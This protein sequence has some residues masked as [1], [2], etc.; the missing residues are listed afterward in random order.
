[1]NTYFRTWRDLKNTFA[2]AMLVVLALGFLSWAQPAKA[3]SVGQIQTG[4]YFAPE[5]V[6]LLRDRLFAGQGGLRQGDVIN[7]IIQF[8][9]VANGATI[10]AGGYVTDYI[11]AGT[12]VV[13]AWFV[14][15]S[16]AGY[17][18]IAPTQVATM[19]DGWG[20]RG[21]GTFNA[22]WTPDAATI[23]ACTNAGYSVATCTARLSE[24]YGDTGIFFS[25][26]PRTAVY[27]YPSTDGRVRQGGGATGNGYYATPTAE[28]QLNPFLFQSSNTTHNYWDAS[29]T[30]AFGSDAIPTAT[31]RSDIPI[32][33]PSGKGAGPFNAGSAVAGPDTGYKLDYTGTQ[34]PWQRIY[35]P[36]SVIGTSALGPATGDGVSTIAGVPTSLGWGLSAG[37]PLPNNTNAV[38]W[39]LGRLT[40]GIPGYVK[41]ALRLTAPPPDSG[42]INNAEVFGGD[43]SADT[44]GKGKDMSWRYH[45]PS[46][47]TANTNLLVFKS[48][49]GM[50]SGST[51]ALAQ[52]CTPVASSGEVIPASFVKLRYR[53]GYLNSGALP[54]TNVQVSEILPFTAGAVKAIEAGN[55]YVVNGID[56]RSALTNSGYTLSNNGAAAGAARGPDVALTS[57]LASTVQQT[58]NFTKLSSLPS[59]NGGTLELDVIVGDDNTNASALAAGARVLNKFSVT[60]TELPA[61]ALAEAVSTVTT[62]ALLQVSKTTSTPST[63]AGGTASYTITV[64]NVGNAAATAI[65][66]NDLL[67]FTGTVADATRRFSYV[68]AAGAP[69]TGTTYGGSTPAGTVTLALLAPPTLNGY[70]ANANQQ[71]VRWTF[72]A[73]STLAAGASFTLTF[74]ATVGSNVPASNV[75]YN[76]D[77]VANY[78]NGSVVTIATA[79]QTAPVNVT[80]PLQVTKSIDCLYNSALTQC[81]AYSGNG[82]V[83]GN[84]KVRY[85]LIYE[86]TGTSAQSNVYLCDQISSA[87]SSPALATSI[88]QPSIAPTP[89]GAYLDA[90]NIGVPAQ[91]AAATDTA[92][93]C[94]YSG[95]NTYAFP[96]IASL[97][98]GA[99]GVVY[100][101]LATNIANTSS[102]NNTGKI[103]NASGSGISSVSVVARDVA[104][105]QVSKTTTTPTLIV[106]GIA[107]YTITL[108]NIGNLAAGNIKVYDFLPFVGTTLDAT[109]RFNYVAGS[110]SGTTLSW[111]VPSTQVG[112]SI[113]P[114]NSN[115]NQQQVLWDLGSTQTLAPGDSATVTFQAQAGSALAT[116]STVY[117]NDV[118]VKFTHGATGTAVVAN[119]VTNT[120]PITI[121]VSLAITKSIDCVYAGATCTAYVS[122]DGL[123]VNA[124]IRYKLSY[125]NIGTVT[126]TDVIL[127]DTL[128]TQTDAGSVSNV[129]LVSG[130]TPPTTT[131]SP[132]SPAGAGATF[133]FATM[134][135]LAVGASGVVTFDVQTTGGIGNTVTNLGKIVS[136]QDPIGQTSS[137]SAVVTELNVTKTIDC[138]YSGTVC[139]AGSYVAGTP[140]TGNAKIRYK[141]AYANPGTATISN[142]TICDQLPTQIQAASATYVTN[143]A[144]TGTAPAAGQTYPAVA[145]C[146]FAN[147]NNFS[148]TS[149]TMDLIAGA[150]GSVLYDVQTNAAA[151]DVVTNLIKLVVGAQI[152]TS[153]VSATVGVPKLVITK[154]ASPTAA[155]LNGAVTYTLTVGNTGNVATT[156]LKV[157]DF[158]PYSGAVA[159]ATKRFAFD[160]TFTPTFAYTGTAAGSP[161]RTEAVPPT[162]APYSGNANQQQV[163]W[164]FGSYAL[165]PGGSVAITFRATVGSAMPELSYYNIGYVEFTSASGPGSVNAVTALV[166]VTNPKPSLVFMKTVGVTSDPVNGATNP[167]NIPGAEVLYTLRVTNTGPGALDSNTLVISDPIPGNTELFVGDLG[168]AVDSGP[169]VFGQGVPTSNLTFTFG[170]LASLT[171]D[172][173]FS[174][175]GCNTWTYVPVPPFDATVNCIRLKPKGAMA[176]SS[177][178]N[179][180]YFDFNFRVRIK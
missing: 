8:A 14:Q 117:G 51:L 157:F 146:G 34:G 49:V 155:Y 166:S 67:P 5:T 66:V 20:P 95:A 83:P 87:Q 29:N 53:I 98:A 164:D 55:V 126:Q 22:N 62:S 176:A 21:K 169:I 90:P 40:V 140:I 70:T 61:G 28:G 32:A 17:T 80:F 180:P 97:A 52:S 48:V 84:A 130:T 74:S 148:Y 45:V 43:A 128:P 150:S 156:A 89:T 121:P 59:S 93:A 57:M 170:S 25:T 72:P 108:T 18:Q 4:K 154:T 44:A 64:A 76:N 101:D 94:G 92:T 35:Y 151:N 65:V 178:G 23:T 13:G 91:I 31:P 104:N 135:S 79:I 172:V 125:Q 145:A 56:I 77:V 36:G 63:A 99:S 149:T 16:G 105:V 11:P 103:A 38:R 122:G 147:S 139:T 167:K 132:A 142:I 42:I 153:S 37:N 138:V 115:P 109:R 47:A 10:G 39:A 58:A 33:N 75:S 82:I 168:A 46:V 119:G 69:G 124:K 165:A 24:V 68:G 106:G 141:V 162:I 110:A 96:V 173:D 41:I 163:L 102:L 54:Q 171:D 160:T 86:N 7:Y 174:N 81:N 15:P 100:F 120:A 107:T 143:F 1:M 175:V 111:F 177:G 2:V 26:D 50:C 12:E 9:T 30:N 73:A 19:A 158:L 131:I 112:P 152:V 129:V 60:S 3:D 127:S 27:T 118:Q 113:A 114:N 179:N 133:S 71:Q 123:P 78:D 159:D 6:D 144:S 134:T 116:G 137:V 88:S 85:K 136:T 161:V